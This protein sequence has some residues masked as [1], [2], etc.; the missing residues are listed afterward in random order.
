VVARAGEGLLI[1]TLA[2]E[3]AAGSVQ[4]T[5]SVRGQLAGALRESQNLS[6]AAGGAKAL[7][8]KATALLQPLIDDIDPEKNGHYP[9]SV[10]G[11]DA[12]EPKGG[13][14]AESRQGQDPVPAFARPLMVLDANMSLNMATPASATVFAGEAIHWTAQEQAHMAAGKTVS[15][16]A[17]KSVG[18]YSHEGGIQVIAQEGPVS[19]Q[20]H[21]D[22]LEWLAKE[23]FTVTSS[24]DEIHVLAKQKITL[25]GG[26]TSIELD[27]AN[28]TLKMPGLLDVKGTSKSFV[29]PKG[30]PAELPLLPTGAINEAQHFIELNHHY[31]DL[32]PVKGAAYKLIFDN[33][34]VIRGKVDD[35]GFARH[36]GVPPG[37]AKVV[38]GEDERKWDGESKRP[39]DRFG[40]ATDADA[41]IALVK[42]LMS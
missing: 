8:L 28:I 36:D 26:Q 18:L 27:G 7:A 2:Q 5:A 24:N 39:N 16:A 30:N 23:G 42:G 31:D 25:K 1:S 12:R 17:G 20:A 9:G 10:N 3:R 35:N 37:S 33:G 22:E 6:D 15:F 40:A 4:D 11:Q 41:A 34:A 38:W 13:E 29:G 32:E 19:V 21:T 14:G